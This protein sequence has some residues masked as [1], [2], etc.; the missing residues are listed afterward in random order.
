[1]AFKITN[2]YDNVFNKQI[3]DV[4][5]RYDKQIEKQELDTS[6]TVTAAE[7][8]YDAAYAD[9]AVQQ[10]INERQIKKS[11]SGAGLSDSGLNR[12]QLTAVQ[13]QKANAD[14]AVSMQK[15][16]FINNAKSALNDFKFN[17]EL[18]RESEINN[19]Q[20]EQ[21]LGRVNK[22]EEII[23]SIS[24]ITD[25]T[26]AAAYIKSV[27][28]QYGIKPE[29]LISYSS[30][31][32]KNG[33]NK[34]LENKN[35]FINRDSYKAL[36]TDLVGYDI[37]TAAGQTAAA[38]AIK[39]WANTHKNQATKSKIKKLLESAGLSYSEY[40]KFLKDGQYFK[41]IEDLKESKKAKA[42]KSGSSGSNEYTEPVIKIDDET[43]NNENVNYDGTDSY[44]PPSA[45]FRFSKV[46]SIK[47]DKN[48]KYSDVE[49]ELDRLMNAGMISD[50]DYKTLLNYYS[51]RYN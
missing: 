8:S 45:L 15:M 13:L 14:N 38:K 23:N 6:N 1:M 10:A 41:D 28:G 40:Q 19:I 4:N 44:G 49:N 33:Y 11:M 29:K 20:N 47:L 26:Q 32:N 5:K 22:T 25:P 46:S 3:K 12:T 31:I 7:N 30:V 39:A 21:E 2:Y 48:T 50:E 43:G 17:A 27:S 36:H 34:Y 9:N 24:S 35:Y 16:N 51:S 18:N 37:T 42:T